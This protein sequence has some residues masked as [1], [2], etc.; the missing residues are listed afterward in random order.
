MAKRVVLGEEER[1]ISGEMWRR[2]AIALKLD[3]RRVFEAFKER[4]G[5][6]EEKAMGIVGSESGGERRVVEMAMKAKAMERM[7]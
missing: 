2:V 4:E 7:K 5:E 6:E 1:K 3:C